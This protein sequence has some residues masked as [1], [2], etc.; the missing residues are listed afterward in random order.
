[1]GRWEAG[2]RLIGRVV[3]KTGKKKKP[4]GGADGG[5]AWEGWV[6]WGGVNG[7]W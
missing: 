4:C 6:G 7:K 1:M 2:E 3:R 5:C